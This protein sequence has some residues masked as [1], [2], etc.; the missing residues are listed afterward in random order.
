MG[1]KAEELG[2]EIY[3]GFA[4]S[5][6]LY[7]E[8]NKV[9]GIGTNDMGVAKDGSKKENFQRGVALKGISLSPPPSLCSVNLSC[10]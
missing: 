5:E 1:V 4:A 6:I 2:V 3:P 7:D 9:V 10:L 8:D